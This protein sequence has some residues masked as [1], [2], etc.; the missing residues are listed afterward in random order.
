MCFYKKKFFKP[1]TIIEFVYYISFW[2]F[3]FKTPKNK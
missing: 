1:K 3:L 2:Y